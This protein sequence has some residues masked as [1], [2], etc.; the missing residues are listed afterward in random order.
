V[1]AARLTRHGFR[2]TI[3]SSIDSSNVSRDFNPREIR[4]IAI[5]DINLL[6]LNVGNSRLAMGVFSAGNL[7]HVK[8]LSHDQRDQWPSAIEEAWSKIKGRD[9]AGIA[10]ASVN[11]NQLEPLEHAAAQVTKQQVEWI[12]REIDLPI[13]VLTENPKET[14][15]DRVLNIAAA[16]EQMGKA[17]VVV[18]AG[19]AITVD[20]CNDAGEFVGGAIAPGVQ[21]MLDALHQNTARLPK[22]P[23]E[24]PTGAFGQS[25]QSAIQQGI[26]HGVRGMVKELAE[27]Y[28]TELGF[29]PDIIAT[30]GDAA[31][32][33]EGWELVHAVAPDLTLYGIALAYANHHIKHQS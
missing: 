6:V 23:F 1:G 20:C 28:A 31:K 33:F 32:L 5:M 16:Y 27:N 2:C 9:N 10:G 24:I 13:K 21:M 3:A 14:G 7:E 15:V 11:P 12:G 25:T 8:R 29:W 22:V 30:G 17:C 19:T 18:D 4:Y 26:Y